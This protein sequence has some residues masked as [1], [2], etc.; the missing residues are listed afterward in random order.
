M[1]SKGI[2]CS[3]YAYTRKV[4]GVEE[5]DHAFNHRT[6]N[7]KIFFA[8]V[9]QRKTSDLFASLYSVNEATNNNV[10]L[11]DGDARLSK[12]FQKMWVSEVLV[13]D[14]E[15]FGCHSAKFNSHFQ[16]YLF[17]YSSVTC[18]AFH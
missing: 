11:Y 18:R 7:S 6:S 9:M 10:V 17:L 13:V 2:I 4:D 15:V 5:C 16:H 14:R 12:Y 8:I 1:V 3:R